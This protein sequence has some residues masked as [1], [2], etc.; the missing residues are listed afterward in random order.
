MKTL[1]DLFEH[2]IQDLYSAEEQLIQALPKMAKKSNNGNLE[3]ALNE[4]LEQTKNHLNRLKSICDRL[5]I[6]GQ[7]EKCLAMEGLIREAEHFMKEDMDP[8]MCSMLG[9]LLRHNALN[10]MKFQ[11]MELR[12]VLRKN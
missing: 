2:Q 11:P 12:L 6:N 4:H 5:G 1:E 3:K 8:K 7:E 9:L 10:T